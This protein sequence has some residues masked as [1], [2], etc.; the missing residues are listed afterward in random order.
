MKFNIKK[1]LYSKFPKNIDLSIVK[2]IFFLSSILYF[3]ILFFKNFSQISFS[4]DF[5]SNRNNIFL[6]FIF[7]ILSIYLNAFA[8]KHI[9]KWFGLE[10][11]K[12]NFVTF[13]VLT[14][15]LKYIP[16]GI[17]HFV[18]RFNFIKEHS[19]SKLAFYTTLIEPYLMMCA[20]FLLAAIGVIYSPF[21]LL[22]LSPLVFLNR[23]LIYFVLRKLT[24]FKGKAL[25]A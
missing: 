5:A 18:E 7:C 9:I 24:S 15:I 6:S 13:F 16:G 10:N 1:S 12:N 23:K 8:W 3:F 2:E 22:L 19:N 17:W 20:S 11:I 4:I 14:N 21:Y 25:E